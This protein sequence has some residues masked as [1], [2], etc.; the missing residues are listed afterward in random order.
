MIPIAQTKKSPA[1]VRRTFLQRF[2]FSGGRSAT[3]EQRRRNAIG[4]AFSWTILIQ[5]V[6]GIVSP[7]VIMIA[8]LIFGTIP[9]ANNRTGGAF[10][11]GPGYPFFHPP[12]WPFYISALI[13]L[14]LAVVTIPL[15]LK[16][17][18]GVGRWAMWLFA[19]YSLASTFI[20]GA[21]WGGAQIPLMWVPV[22]LY[23]AT[24]AI[25]ALRGLLGLLHLLP[26]T[27]RL[28]S[29]QLAREQAP[30]DIAEAPPS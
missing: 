15:P 28:S 25:L 11:A 30:T 5:F 10:N 16:A 12:I 21:A 19:L 26:K 22:C 1:R 8:G 18:G 20:I 27:W 29:A 23:L 3:P 17:S 13:A 7:L 2:L 4:S 6:F 14:V 24:L 9:W